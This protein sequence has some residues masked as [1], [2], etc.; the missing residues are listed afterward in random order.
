MRRQPLA[1]QSIGL[2]VIRGGLRERRFPAVAD[3]TVTPE[4]GEARMSGDEEVDGEDAR[5]DSS[6]ATN[7]WGVR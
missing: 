4:V 5:V 7:L 1:T 3:R 2:K 6:Q